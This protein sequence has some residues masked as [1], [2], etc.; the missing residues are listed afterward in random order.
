MDNQKK[1]QELLQE[2]QLSIKDR[3]WGDYMHDERQHNLFKEIAAKFQMYRH[4]QDQM[5]KTIDQVMK[6]VKD[7]QNTLQTLYPRVSSLE[8]TLGALSSKIDH[9]DSQISFFLSDYKNLKRKTY[10]QNSKKRVLCDD[11]D[12][13]D[14]DNS[15]ISSVSN[16]GL[17]FS[18]NSNEEINISNTPHKKDDNE[19]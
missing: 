7:D 18:Y 3:R 6:K 13:S 19:E 1:F 9:L 8:T 17:E 12:D 4:S 15:I 11:S 10:F 5:M 14:T 2:L 16:L